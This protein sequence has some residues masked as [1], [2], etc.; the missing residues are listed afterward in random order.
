MGSSSSGLPY[1]VFMVG[2]AVSCSTS[3]GAVPKT[4]GGADAAG[5]AHAAH[6]P[7]GW[8]DELAPT[9]LEDL[10][11]RPGAVRFRLD[12]RVQ[13]VDVKGT[14]LTMWTY[15]GLVPGPLI[16]AKKGDH[17]VLEFTNSLPASTTVHWHGLRVPNAMDG[18]GHDA[19]VVQSGGTFRFEFD[20][21]DAGTYW[22]HSHVNSSAQVGFGLYGALVVEDPSD[23]AIGDEVPIVFSDLSENPDGG[24]A[25]GDQDGRFGDYFG[26]E[27]NVLLVNGKVMPNLKGR[28]GV[29]QR[30]KVINA[31]RARYLKFHVP[32]AD[33]VRVGG[34]AGLISRP[35]AITSITLTPGERTELRVLPKV[36]GAGKQPVLWEDSDRLHTGSARASVPFM[37]FETTN[38]A[39]PRN[40]A[41]ALPKQLREIT[42]IPTTGSRERIMEMT[43]T[44]GALGTSLG[45]NGKPF[46]EATPL[47]AVVGETEV[48]EVRNLTLQDHPFHLHGFSFQVMGSPSE[49]MTKL[50]WK[51]T[52]NVPANGFVKLVLRWDDRP[53]MWMFHCHILDHVELGMMGMVHLMRH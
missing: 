38:Q 32:G 19:P 45:F 48:W 39:A 33:M 47:D 36:R 21:T 7:D 10:D 50:E 30:W 40:S 5:G 53:G 37:T 12:A 46:T 49:P 22:Y 16:R 11:P 44:Q 15:N 31:S 14:R 2:L 1:R 29:A 27:G 28:I 6:Q 8:K 34:D 25:P 4:D 24:L 20:L 42:P 41:E 18:A 17:L 23:P 51:D 52:V 13:E 3:N 43:E 26:R 35:S 9:E